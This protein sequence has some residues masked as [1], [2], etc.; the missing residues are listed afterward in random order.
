MAEN[1]QDGDVIGLAMDKTGYGPDGTAWGGEKAVREPWRISASLLKSTYG[2]SWQ[3]IAEN[4]NVCAD[5]AQRELFNK[6]IDGKINSPQSSG[7]GRLFDGVAAL[8]GLRR[9][10]SFEG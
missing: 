6:I 1:Q 3:E 7:L 4:L 5:Q 8:L 2:A 9:T 10:V